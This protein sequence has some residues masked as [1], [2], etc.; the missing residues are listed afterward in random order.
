[1]MARRPELK[2]ERSPVSRGLSPSGRPALSVPPRS[3]PLHRGRDRQHLGLADALHERVVEPVGGATVAPADHPQAVADS[4]ADFWTLLY[5]IPGF[6][7]PRL[8]A[9]GGV[10]AKVGLDAA[11]YYDTTPLRETLCSLID[12]AVLNAAHPRLTVGAVNVKSGELRYF[13]SR[14]ESIAMEHVMASGALPIA[15]APSTSASA[16]STATAG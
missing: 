7:S 13:D 14:D 8:P 11:S 16:R 12:L 4:V 15:R 10:Q 1:M 2:I 6:F 3:G 5:G 9:W